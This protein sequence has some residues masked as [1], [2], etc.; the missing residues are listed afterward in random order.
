MAYSI[1]PMQSVSKWL[2]LMVVE[3]TEYHGVNMSLGTCRPGVSNFVIV[4]RIGIV[5]DH[6]G[7]VVSVGLVSRAPHPPLHWMSRAP[8]LPYITVHPP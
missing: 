3:S 8:T 6:K 7:P 2:L 4:G 5:F 1:I